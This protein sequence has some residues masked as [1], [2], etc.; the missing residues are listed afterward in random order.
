MTHSSLASRFSVHGALMD[1]GYLRETQNRY[2]TQGKAEAVRHAALALV[3]L[4]PAG[5]WVASKIAGL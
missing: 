1:P 2:P 3:F 5:L 4:L